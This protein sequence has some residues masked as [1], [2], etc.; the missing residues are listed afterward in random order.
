MNLSH[1]YP[2]PAG[3]RGGL[4]GKKRVKTGTYEHGGRLL[5]AAAVV[6]RSQRGQQS[7]LR[8]ATYSADHPLIER[9]CEH[10]GDCVEENPL[11]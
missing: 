1:T 6:T 7:I 11:C 10:C 5:G 8:R 3:C 2:T 9:R 4:G